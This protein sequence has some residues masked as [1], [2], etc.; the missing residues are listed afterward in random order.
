M[1]LPTPEEAPAFAVSI[2]KITLNDSNIFN[3]AATPQKTGINLYRNNMALN[4]KRKSVADCDKITLKQVK[5]ILKDYPQVLVLCEKQ[6]SVL[7]PSILDQEFETVPKTKVFNFTEV[8]AKV[9]TDHGAIQFPLAPCLTFPY[10]E[11]TGVVEVRVTVGVGSGGSLEIGGGYPFPWFGVNAATSV[12]V[13]SSGSIYVDHTCSTNL[14]GV[15]P[16][17]SIATVQTQIKA[18]QWQLADQKKFAQKS[19]WY[20]S[21]NKLLT[22]DAPLISCVSESYV[23]GICNLPERQAMEEDGEFLQLFD[24]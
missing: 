8:A 22:D 7:Y 19:K 12:A 3:V 1:A 6:K 15:R 17:L 14:T 13:G 10:L 24:E 18:R 11:G 2:E 4:V 16:L 9:S 23:P 5:A 20:K 21:K